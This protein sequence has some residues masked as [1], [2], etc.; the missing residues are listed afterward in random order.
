MLRERDRNWTG[1]VR[2]SRLPFL[3]SIYKND[4]KVLLLRFETTFPPHI[5]VLVVFHHYS[6]FFFFCFFFFFALK[7]RGFYDCAGP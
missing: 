6:F 4:E 7:G 2:Q 5:F 1:L 3:L